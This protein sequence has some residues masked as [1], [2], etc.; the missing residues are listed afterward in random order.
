MLIFFDYQVEQFAVLG[1]RLNFIQIVLELHRVQI[2]KAVTSYLTFLAW[3]EKS[4]GWL[5]WL[6]VVPVEDIV[7]LGTEE[8]FFWDLF[9]CDLWRLWNVFAA[10]IM[11]LKLLLDC[12]ILL[13]LSGSGHF[14]L[15]FSLFSLFLLPTE[16]PLFRCL[17]RLW[18][19]DI[20]LV[21]VLLLHNG[22]Y[23]FVVDFVLLQILPSVSDKLSHFV[24]DYVHLK[25]LSDWWSIL[26]LLFKQQFD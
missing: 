19:V 11:G 23:I 26:W 21:L 2:V 16:H 3:I 4:V 18:N 20:I 15:S 17:L 14:Q 8:L 9:C 24:L 12:R 13:Y 7:F 22:G 10:I 25:D 6:P 5:C 1:R